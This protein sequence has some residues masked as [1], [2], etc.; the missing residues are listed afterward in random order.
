MMEAAA[1]LGDRLIVIV[2]NDD[3]QLM[4]KGRIIASLDDRI[5]IVRGWSPAVAA[6]ARSGLDHR[7]R[8][9]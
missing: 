8:S 5:E 2:N 7:E 1:E 9:A 6:T 3:Q 4:K